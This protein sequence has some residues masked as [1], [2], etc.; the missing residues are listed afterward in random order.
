ML[1]GDLYEL[2][3]WASPAFIVT[4]LAVVAVLSVRDARRVPSHATVK[5]I[6]DGQETPA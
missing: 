1:T 3:A 6:P 4:V 2:P 5:D